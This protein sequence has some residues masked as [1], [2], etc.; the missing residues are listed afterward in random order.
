MKQTSEDFH[1]DAFIGS[2][3][4][5]EKKIPKDQVIEHAPAKLNGRINGHVNGVNGVNGHTSKKNTCDFVI[6]GT[7]FGI[8]GN[9]SFL[10]NMVGSS[11]LSHLLL[12]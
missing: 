9:K 12:F 4:R 6:F 1:L 11:A 3:Q 5:Y 2:Y 8:V 7:P 10:T